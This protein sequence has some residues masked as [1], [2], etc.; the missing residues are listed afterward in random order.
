MKNILIVDD[1]LT[2]QI[3][4]KKILEDTGYGV[5][6]VSS[7][8]EGLSKFKDIKF[9]VLITD[10]KMP[11]VDGIE[12]TKEVL[13]RD[14]DI[15]VILI[16][17]YGSIRSAVEA[18]RYGA[19]DYL[20]KPVDKNE[21]LITI[22]RGLERVALIKENELLKQELGKVEKACEFLTENS[23]L[24]EVLHDA[25]LVARSDSTVLITGADGTGKEV[26][27]RYI[28]ENSLRKEHKFVSVNCATIPKVLLESELFGHNKGSFKGAAEEHKGYF[29]IAEE[30][31]IFLD[32]IGSI[33]PLLQIKLLNAI[34]ER[35]FTRI[36][37]NKAQSTNADRTDT[38]IN[39]ST[40]IVSI[41]HFFIV[42]GVLLC[43]FDIN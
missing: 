26:L 23:K 36:G 17:A 14:R 18:L 9:D 22:R 40:G 15:V 11:D 25:K 41:I 12:L 1:E 16:T 7:G 34:K 43:N 8:S 20:P 31:T 5:M 6:A 37:S 42:C 2:S 29:E 3:S 19:Y 35:K 10:L 32:E 27:A 38:D 28:H 30:G 21:L 39:M 13:K 24:K 4:I 33:D